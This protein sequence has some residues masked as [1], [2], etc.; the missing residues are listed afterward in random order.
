MQG[1]I[2]LRFTEWLIRNCDPFRWFTFNDIQG[3]KKIY[4]LPRRSIE[5]PMATHAGSV[6]HADV[7]ASVY[8]FAIDEMTIDELNIID[9]DSFI[10]YGPVSHHFHD[11]STSPASL[12][13]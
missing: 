7:A 9:H 3:A 13:N 10:R 11:F 6:F 12:T 4:G 2:L 1:S 8:E 5:S